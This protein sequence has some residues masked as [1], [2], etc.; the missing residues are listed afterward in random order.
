MT[1]NPE[2]DITATRYDATTRTHYYTVERG[3]QRWTVAVAD[4]EFARFGPQTGAQA[5][6]NQAR[7]RNYLAV[8]L[9]AAMQGAADA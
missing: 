7:R 9:N 8:K 2:T 3:V 4:D 1:I 6:T 5:K